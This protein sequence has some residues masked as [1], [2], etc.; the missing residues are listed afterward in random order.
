MKLLVA[1]LTIC[2]VVQ[3]A[4]LSR[5]KAEH[6]LEKRA[7]MALDNAAEALK[8]ARQSYGSGDMA[9]A[10]LLLDEVAESVNLAFTSL[11]DTGKDPTKSPKH[12]KRAELKTRGLLKRLDAFSDEMDLNDRPA[13]EKVKGSVQKVHEEVLTGIMEGWK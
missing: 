4:D 6:N 5:A 12:F 11:K 3:A 8:A 7:G 10:R 1:F 2:A 13:V 9:K